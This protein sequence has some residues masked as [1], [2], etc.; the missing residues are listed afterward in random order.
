VLDPAGE[1]DPEVRIALEPA[2]QDARELE[3]LGLHP[4]RMPG[5]VRDRA[6]VELGN[7]AVA[8]AA[9][10]KLRRRQALRGQVACGAEALE[11]VERRRM[12]RRRARF[13]AQMRRCLEHRHRDAA[14]DELRGRAQAHRPGA[15]DEDAL[16]ELH[17]R[18]RLMKSASMRCGSSPVKLV[19]KLA[20]PALMAAS[21]G[22][23][24][25]WRMSAFCSRTACA[26]AA[27]IASVHCAAAASRSADG[28][29][30]STSP[31]A[32]AF[33]ASMFSPSST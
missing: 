32:S 30:F 29:T 24:S 9:V 31:M 2:E 33:V 27:R 16:L 17:L 6:E 8:L 12:K 22:S 1:L 26:P 7:H 21:S 19:R 18:R 13:L 10:L 4:I 11:H 28:T 25:H 3:L 5:Q 14:P 20:M 15:G 23:F